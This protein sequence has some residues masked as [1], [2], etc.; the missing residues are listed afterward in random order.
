MQHAHVIANLELVSKLVTWSQFCE[1][2]CGK[3][4]TEARRNA[5]LEP[6]GAAVIATT[7]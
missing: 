4:G 2:L 7:C 5:A 1:Y 3:T 6:G